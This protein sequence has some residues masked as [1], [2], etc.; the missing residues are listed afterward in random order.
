VGHKPA[1]QGIE[2]AAR[3][4]PVLHNPEMAVVSLAVEQL[5]QVLLLARSQEKSS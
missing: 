1:E 2:E 5:M 4:E 3:R